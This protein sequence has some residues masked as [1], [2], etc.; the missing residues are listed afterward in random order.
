[1]LACKT[2][3]PIWKCHTKGGLV[4]QSLFNVFKMLR[5]VVVLDEAHKAYGASKREANVEFAR[6]IS[7]LD[8]RMV[9]ELSATPNHGISNLLVD[10]DGNR[11]EKKKK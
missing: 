5:P 10:I 8:P 3:T 4:K 7:R 11:S 2:N 1:M 9:I 6:S